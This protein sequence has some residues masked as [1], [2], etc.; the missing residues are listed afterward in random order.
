MA[1]PS[2]NEARV[3]GLKYTHGSGSTTVSAADTVMK[4]PFKG[5]ALKPYAFVNVDITG[6]PESEVK[7]CVALFDP[8]LNKITKTAE[9]TITLAASE[10]ESIT[11]T[12][13]F[14]DVVGPFYWCPFINSLD[15]D[16]EVKITA[17]ATTIKG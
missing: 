6:P 17:V 7:V 15:E 14:Y 16:V 13:S 11:E 3:A 10:E 9:R 5:N 2:Q 1:N 8:V 4:V 12:H